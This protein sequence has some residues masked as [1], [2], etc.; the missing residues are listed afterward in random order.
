MAALNGKDDSYPEVYE[1]ANYDTTQQSINPTTTDGRD[2]HGIEY[3]E[4]TR[5]HR[6]LKARQITMI[7]GT[8][9]N[10]GYFD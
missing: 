9:K 3:K 5:L 7:V 10:L 1:K 2:I 4:G 6:G 8:P